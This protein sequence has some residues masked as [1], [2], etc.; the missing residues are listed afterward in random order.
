[1]KSYVETRVM[2]LLLFLCLLSACAKNQLQGWVL[3][4]EKEPAKGKKILIKADPGGKSTY[5]KP[6]G[7][8]ILKGLEPSKVYTIIA[9][10]E[11]DNTRARVDNI[12]INKGK[13]SLPENK[14]LIL[15]THL[16]AP[17][18]EDTSKIEE[19]GKGRTVPEHP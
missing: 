14:M 6:D 11:A 17:P 7:S 10:C 16:L 4:P 15:T 5:V 8:F 2:I 3:T 9:I 18:S 1:M 13:T 19:P 12:Y